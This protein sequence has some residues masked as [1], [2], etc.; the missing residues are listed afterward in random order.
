MATR[1]DVIVVGARCAGASTAMLLARRGYKVLLVDRARFPS[2]IPHGHF[3]HRDGPRRLKR[4]GLLDK[5][6]ASN[7]PP[8]MTSTSD[9]GDFPLLARNLVLDDVAWGYGPRRRV[10]DKILVEAAVAA[11]AELREGF[12]V[13]DFLGDGGAISGVRGR[14]RAG[15]TPASERARITIGA[16]GRNSHLA[17]AVKT[18]RYREAPAIL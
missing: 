4:W 12:A 16:D 10:F 3:I 2:D 13:E 11:G 9:F 6:I 17:R 14:D 1:N 15:G 7:C 8:V 18:P 5:V